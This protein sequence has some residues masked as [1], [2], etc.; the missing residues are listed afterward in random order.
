MISSQLDVD[1]LDVVEDE[2][3][4]LVMAME[5]RHAEEL[6]ILEAKVQKLEPYAA[7][8]YPYPACSQEQVRG[9]SQLC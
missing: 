4:N 9:I 7:G 2:V 1:G 5:Q 6:R 3:V 8:R